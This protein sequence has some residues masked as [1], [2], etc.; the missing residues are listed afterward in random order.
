MILVPPPCTTPEIP[1]FRRIPPLCAPHAPVH[2]RL[3]YSKQYE[4]E[5]AQ[6]LDCLF[7]RSSQVRTPAG[8][9]FAL[10]GSSHG[11]KRQSNSDLLHSFHRLP[12]TCRIPAHR[13][14]SS[15]AL[16][17]E[18]SPCPARFAVA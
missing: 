4:S 16:A 11:L 14:D 10:D 9:S 3:C 1:R 5:G 8:K 15:P 13:V 12:K 17:W 2:T 18:V 7:A 6:P